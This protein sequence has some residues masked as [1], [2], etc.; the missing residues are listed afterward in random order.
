MHRG[1]LGA[2]HAK[3]QQR[4]QP[5]FPNQ[6]AVPLL[7]LRTI[8]IAVLTAVRSSTTDRM[9]TTMHK[10]PWFD[11]IEAINMA[12][13]KRKFKS[14]DFFPIWFRDKGTPYF[15][16]FKKN[17]SIT[18]IQ[19][20]ELLAL[21]RQHVFYKHS[22]QRVGAIAFHTTA[23]F[24]TTVED[25]VKPVIENVDFKEEHLS[26]IVKIYWP[27]VENA[28]VVDQFYTSCAVF[29]P[30][31]LEIDIRLVCAESG[32][33]HDCG[34]SI[35]VRKISKATQ[36]DFYAAIDR[37]LDRH[38]AYKGTLQFIP[39]SSED[40][41]DDKDI[42]YVKDA[43]QNGLDGV[44]LRLEKFHM[45]DRSLVE[46]FQDMQGRYD[47]R[48]LFREAGDYKE[49]H[50]P[51]SDSTL[52]LIYD[53]STNR[54]NPTSPGNDGYYICYH[55]LYCNDSPFHVFDENKPAWLAHI[56]IPHTLLG[57]MLNLTKPWP[58][59]RE[60]VISD[61]FG[62]TGTTWFEA[63]KHLNARCLSGDI[64]PL[65]PLLVSD[66][67]CF[68][69]LPK[70]ELLSHIS[71]LTELLGNIK[72]RG[73]EG[74]ESIGQSLLTAI[75]DVTYPP[76]YMR[77][78]AIIR[79]LKGKK[80]PPFLS[81]EFSV[82]TAE[83]VGKLSLFDRLIFYV[84][85]RAELRY[86]SAYARG[87]KERVACFT[88]EAEY[89]V[90][91]MTALFAW[92]SRAAAEEA[93]VGPFSVFAGHYSRAC[94][95]RYARLVEVRESLV[96][97]RNVQVSDARQL[98]PKTFDIIVTDPPYGVNTLEDSLSE[99]YAEIIATIVAAVRNDGH[100]VISLPGETYN[101]V[102]LPVCTASQIVTE[103]ILRTADELG[104][105]TY[106]PAR[107]SMP[108]TTAPYYW[109]SSS[110][111]RVVLHFRIRDKAN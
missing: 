46:I 53:R 5:Q 68:F 14:D 89:L 1:L 106:I 35:F 66:N 8:T 11:L 110:L 2:R 32:Y 18:N 64:N 94:G 111:R 36:F 6:H 17:L 98:P 108:M 12:T 90:E 56:T 104:R 57:A 38:S 85:L 75:D 95:I 109:N 79:K 25:I 19:H 105:E 55:Q 91:E 97:G 73:S 29:L 61:P 81:F 65:F 51:T 63:M 101:G 41:G 102:P 27:I 23:A 62:G 39:F 26:D 52:W 44:K 69:S 22:K 45:K 31:T 43:L 99:L 42:G 10:Q 21:I 86:Q 58:S 49:K 96:R 60:V 50:P 4:A 87:A 28:I 54:S 7:L 84:A 59:D 76:S 13:E 20:A 48:L 15:F 37:H 9:S 80:K 67:I 40:F 93:T 74:R 92:C 70:Q 83:E 107:S 30:P 72:T 100:L 78:V 103:Q 82:E 24:T 33:I 34:Y 88:T 47:R 16:L 71:A 3:P 77:A